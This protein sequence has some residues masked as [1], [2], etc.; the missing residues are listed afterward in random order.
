MR[1]R[2]VIGLALGSSLVSTIPGRSAFDIRDHLADRRAIE[3]IYWAHRTWPSA[4]PGSKPALAAVLPDSLLRNRVEDDLR[5]GPALARFWRRPVT[6]EQVQ[7]E[8]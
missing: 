4:N 8:M 6:A 1:I 7:E 3:S 2:W 5:K